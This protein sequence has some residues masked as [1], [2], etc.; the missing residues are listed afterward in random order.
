[1][2]FLRNA[3][4]GGPATILGLGLIIFVHEFGH[5][6]VAKLFGVRVHVLSLGFGKRLWGFDLS[7]TD[8][9]V[10]ALPLGGYVHMAGVQPEDSTGEPGDFHM[11]PRW[12]RILVYLAGPA[13]NVVLAVL[14]I[15]GVFMV[16][17]QAQGM[18][19][20]PPLI[21]QVADGYPAA[22]AGLQPGDLVVAV[23]GEPMKTWSD[24]SFLVGTSPDKALIL[25]IERAGETRQLTLRPGKDER[26]QGVLA[27]LPKFELRLS[28][29]LRDTPAHRAGLK[30]GDAVRAVDGEPVS[31]AQAFVDLVQPLAGEEIVLTVDRRGELLDFPIVPAEV[32]GK[33][34]IGVRLGIYSPLPLLEAI[35]A[36]VRFN[37]DI[38][39]KTGQVL[40]KLFTRQVS[41]RSTFSGPVEI[42]VMTTEAAIRGPKDWVF[43]VGFLSISI[44]I[45]NLLPIPILDGGHITIL[46][47]E[48]T[49][50]RDLSVRVKEG[51]NQVGF[52]LLMMLMAAVI[53]WDLSK[54]LPGLFG[55]G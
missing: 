21:G 10:S 6:I 15:A 38:V 22:E 31:E 13:M 52:V 47:A 4:I 26:G 18:Q 45:M 36:S 48:S 14:L 44:G 12:Q 28:T 50:R 54:N 24:F 42:A 11:K 9:R 29:I 27:A 33:G 20:V 1:M 53:F 34:Q 5:F 2:E 8:Y 30:A 46:L 37:I 3:L 25:D 39:K 41:A 32:E 43:L 40:G 7:G 55:G 23:D 17:H 49:I 35:P 16:G 51:F 19:G